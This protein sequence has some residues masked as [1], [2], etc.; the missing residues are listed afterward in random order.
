ML[1]ALLPYVWAY[2]GR[3]LVALTLLI[4]AKI[5]TVAV[6][7]VLKYIVDALDASI[8]T[9]LVLPLGLLL[10]YG[11]LRLAS[12]TF[13][14]LRNIIFARMRYGIMRQI[15]LQVVEH[16]HALSLRFHLD[17][18]TGAITRDISRGT[19]SISSLL[20]YLLFRIVPTVVEIALVAAILLG[21]YTPWFAL[22]VV[23]TFSLYVV[24]TLVITEWRMKYRVAMNRAE[25]EANSHAI[26]GLL[27]YETVKYFGNEGF[28]LDRYGRNL[29]E[30]Q[31]AAVQSQ[32]SLSF[33]NI[34]QRALIAIGVTIVMILAAHGV[35]SGEMTVGDLVAVN[36][37]L[38]Q[39][40]MPLGFLGMIYSI[41]KN[42]FSDM[43]RMFE[44]MEAEPEIVDVD[45][46]PALQVDR[47]EIRF[48]RVNFG[49]DLNRQVLF[50]LDLHIPPGHKLAV[51]GPS[52]SGK[53]T[54]ARLLFRFYDVWDG[55]IR[56]DGQKLTDVSQDSLRA[57]IGIVP[58]DTV[59]FND[60][61]LFNIQ[62]GN[63]H[64]TPE[65]VERAA[66]MASI[67]DFI[68]SLPDGY[69][70]IVG[71]RGLKLS[72]GE[73]QRVAIAR[74]ILK[75]PSILIFDEA[76]SSLD[77]ASESAINAA[78]ND[79][80]RDRTTL[81]IAHRLSTIVDA[82]EIVVLD[83][84]RILERGT[85]SQLL[86]AD[87]AYAHMWRLQQRDDKPSAP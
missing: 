42:A 9:S 59:L 62:Y 54:L 80:S 38:L 64:A 31:R 20:N 4:G 37:Y 35:V 50:N 12:S 11:A 3:T 74:A 69:E 8:S 61:I 41:L 14:E 24:F 19:R 53:S 84:G 77:S 25:S 60:T 33:L 73:K 5:A 6:P 55:S 1:R 79:V 58:Q 86:A 47:A 63:L 48:S 76:T 36:A 78:L 49:Y 15:S 34:G 29:A 87:G 65:Q 52:G 72:G 67:H 83:A 57:A 23:A 13:E 71:E 68:E 30:W 85:H 32:S 18:K 40:F 45:D 21:N 22:V 27:N 46:A 16:L 17:R 28:E 2:R 81:V 51:V 39:V 10:G 82:D 43:E 70:T 75:N 26:D 44:L 66:R 56:I 7:M